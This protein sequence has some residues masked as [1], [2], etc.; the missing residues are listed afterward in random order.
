MGSS[1]GS[2]TTYHSTPTT[3]TN[4]KKRRGWEY[5][6]MSAED[7]QDWIDAPP[8]PWPDVVAS[9]APRGGWALCSPHL[10]SLW[11]RT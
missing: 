1:I 8:T 3:T 11:G 7:P 4:I 9:A 5:S 2:S 6:Y 10:R